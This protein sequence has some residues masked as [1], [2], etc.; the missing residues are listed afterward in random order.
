VPIVL[1]SAGRVAEHRVGGED[2]LEGHV[3]LNAVRSITRGARVR[4]VTTKQNAVGVA[5]VVC[6][7]VPG[8]SQDGVKVAVGCLHGSF[9]SVAVVPAAVT[10]GTTL[11]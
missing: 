8:E 3:G 10:A 4:M 7:G 5:D 6:G 9:G 11:C 1:G 2:L